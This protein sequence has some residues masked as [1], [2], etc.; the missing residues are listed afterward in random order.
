MPDPEDMRKMLIAARDDLM[1]AADFLSSD[2]HF[3]RAKDCIFRARLIEDL[4][5]IERTPWP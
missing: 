1:V 3:G 5:Q 2:G 4:L